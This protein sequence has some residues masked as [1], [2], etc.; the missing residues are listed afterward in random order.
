M[1]FLAIFFLGGILLQFAIGFL[2][3]AS[4]P[5]AVLLGCCAGLAL[6]IRARRWAAHEQQDA[7]EP[8]L[9]FDPGQGKIVAF[10]E[11]GGLHHGYERHAA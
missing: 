9:P 7:P 2:L 5:R 11:V 6:F 1:N 10:P 4:S 8:R 3:D